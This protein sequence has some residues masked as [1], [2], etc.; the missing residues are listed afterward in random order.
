M[1]KKVLL[2]NDNTEFIESLRKKLSQEGFDPNWAFDP[3]S[4]ILKIR[5]DK[6]DII[7]IDVLIPKSGCL[8]FLENLKNEK[9]QNI[10]NIPVIVTGDNKILLSA[11]DDRGVKDYLVEPY[12]AWDIVEKVKSYIGDA[13]GQKILVVDD[14][15]D[16]RKIIAFRLKANGFS[17]NT[18]TNGKEALEKI[19]KERPDLIVLDFLMPVMDGFAFLKEFRKNPDYNH[20]P[21][22]MLT[23]RGATKESFETLGVDDFMPKPFDNDEL[24]EKI[25]FLLKKKGIALSDDSRVSNLLKE[26]FETRKYSILIT[27]DEKVILDKLNKTIYRVIIAY[28][29][30]IKLKPSEFIK[31]IRGSRNKKTPIIIY[32]NSNVPGTEKDNIVVIR[33]IEQK[34]LKEGINDFFDKRIAENDLPYLIE[35]YMN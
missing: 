22:L 5:G 12:T 35:K 9:D 32:S 3:E 21:V 18:A 4:A 8:Q 7:V 28:L 26:I 24:N 20:I 13:K 23:A 11:L 29:P 10:R 27:D 2:I 25:R 15:E 33:D 31:A 19:T 1:A 16:I 30:S 17:V 6:P 34:W 14:E